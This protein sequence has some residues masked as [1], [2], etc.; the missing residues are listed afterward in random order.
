VDDANSGGVFVQRFL[1]NRVEGA[2]SAMK[3]VIRAVL[4]IEDRNIL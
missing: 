3:P 1:V 2:D 4:A